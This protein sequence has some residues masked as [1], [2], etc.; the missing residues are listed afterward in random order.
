MAGEQGERRA[1][2]E[3]GSG[4]TALRLGNRENLLRLAENAGGETQ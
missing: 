2:K 3:P 4:V 1:K